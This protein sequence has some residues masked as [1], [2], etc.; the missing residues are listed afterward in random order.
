MTPPRAQVGDLIVVHH[1]GSASPVEPERFSRS[2]EPATTST[3]GSGGRT[4]KRPSSRRA[5]TRSSGT[6]STLD[7]AGP[8]LV[9]ELHPIDAMPPDADL[10]ARP[11][12]A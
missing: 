6:W 10:F 2:S 8:A 12:Y 5:A 7:E 3:T 1:T 9:D 4:V 11:R